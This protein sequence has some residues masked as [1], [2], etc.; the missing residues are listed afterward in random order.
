MLYA[1]VDY[2][3]KHGSDHAELVRFAMNPMALCAKKKI[4]ARKCFFVPVVPLQ[5][6]HVAKTSPHIFTQNHVDINK[7]R[8]G[9]FISKPPMPSIKHLNGTETWGPA[10]SITPYFW[11]GKT[12]D[13]ELANMETVLVEHKGFK[14]P[15]LRNCRVVEPNEQLLTG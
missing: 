9:V 15:I 12:H 3:Q 1:L 14:I 2:H 4:G 11:L 7:D 10:L 13:K 6:I 8:L 5:C